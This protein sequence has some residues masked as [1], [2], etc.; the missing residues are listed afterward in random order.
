MNGPPRT[1]NVC[2]QFKNAGNCT[3]G[4]NC[5]FSHDLSGDKKDADGMMEQQ[6]QEAQ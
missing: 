5:R 3:Y 6:P 1:N 2:Y 4:A